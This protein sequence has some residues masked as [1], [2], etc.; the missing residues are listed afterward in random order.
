M[1]AL[2]VFHD[3]LNEE[4]DKQARRERVFRDITQVLDTMTDVELIERYRFPRVT[5]LDLVNDLKDLIQPKTNRSHSIPAHIQHYTLFQVLTCLRFL[6]KGD[7][8]SEVADL[9]G[10]SK[11][12]ACMIIHRVVDAI[13]NTLK[14]IN[15]TTSTDELRKIKSQFYK[16]AGFL[17]V[18]GAID[19]TQIPIQ[20]MSLEDEPVYICRKGYHSINVQAVVN[21]DL[22]FTNAVCKFPGATHD[23]YILQSSSLPNLVSSLEDG[24]WLV[25]DSGYPLKEWLMTPLSNPRTGQEE[26]Y[27]NAHCKTRN[28]IERAFGVLKARFRCLHKTGGALPYRPSKCT[29]IIECTMRLHNLAIE[30]GIPL[31]EAVDQ[32]DADGFQFEDRD[33][34]NRTASEVRTRLIQRF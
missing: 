16:I 3:I 15:F 9:H 28:V 27:N 32:E 30:T 2:I 22:R 24:G 12:S 14:N 18:V 8:L 21:P 19:G 11:A 4:N 7:D 5:I 26:K 31:L 23:A 20:G 17:S 25:G 33:N 29:R 6:A 13:C 10:I 34:A 1:A